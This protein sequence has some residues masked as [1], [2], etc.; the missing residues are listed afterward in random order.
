MPNNYGLRWQILKRDEFTCQYCGQHAPNVIL[1]V[2]HRLPRAAGG[3]DH[4]DN[5][6]TACAACNI[7]K[8]VDGLRP[9]ANPTARVQRSFLADEIVEFISVRGPASA[10]TLA[11]EL[12]RNRSNISAA[13]NNSP[14]FEA[15]PRN[16]HSVRFQIRS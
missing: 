2:D 10:T 8:N 4:P 6:V 16:G 7:G 15:L 13:L 9:A 3:S 5:L 12:K 1:H 14:L 11:K